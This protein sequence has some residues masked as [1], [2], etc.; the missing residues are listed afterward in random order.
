MR[1]HSTNTAIEHLIAIYDSVARD[2]PTF[3]KR[4]IDRV[5]RRSEQIGLYP[6][7][8]REVPE[9]MA[10]DLREVLEEPYRIIC[11]ISSTRVDVIAVVHAARNIKPKCFDCCRSTVPPS[12][13]EAGW[14]G[15]ARRNL[16]FPCEPYTSVG[17]APAELDP[18]HESLCHQLRLPS[19]RA[20]IAA[21]I[22]RT[23]P[24][25]MGKSSQQSGRSPSRSGNAANRVETAANR[26]WTHTN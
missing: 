2:S 9:F 18:P 20:R 24:W 12:K 5:T 3:A 13:S 11:K 1:V 23:S 19:P 16:P 7:S 22:A 15:E 6:D 14:A 8:G 21:I 25:P 26:L 4:L 17:F 10:D